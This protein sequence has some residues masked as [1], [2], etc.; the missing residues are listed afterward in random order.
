MVTEA[1]RA[2]EMEANEKPDPTGKGRAL[3]RGEHTL[4]SDGP[5]LR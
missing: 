1:N 2:S 4:G 3:S 5:R